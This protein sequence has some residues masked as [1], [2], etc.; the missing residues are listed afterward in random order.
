MNVT[1]DLEMNE[2][3]LNKAIERARETLPFWRSL[4]VANKM[5][6]LKTLKDIIYQR[7]D[8]IA[9]VLVADSARVRFSAE[10]LVFEV[11]NNFFIYKEA[12]RLL[13]KST[14]VTLNPIVYSSKNA[15]VELVPY[16]VVGIISPANSPFF[17]SFQQIIQAVLMGNTVVVKPSEATPQV[18][19]LIQQL[20]SE[21]KVPVGVINIIHGGADLGEKIVHSPHID[22]VILYGKKD[23]GQRALEYSSQTLKPM[24]LGLGGNEAAIVLDD[25]FFERTVNGL[26][27]GAFCNA[28]Q[29][30]SCIRR[31]IAVGDIG[32]QLKEKLTERIHALNLKELEAHE[33]EIGIVKKEHDRSELLAAVREAVEQ[34]ATVITGGVDSR[35][36]SRIRPFFLTDVRPE[37]KIMQEEFMGP[38][39]CLYAVRTVEEAI[40]VANDSC[41]G[42]TGS[43]WTSDFHEGRRIARELH[44]GTVWINESQFYHYRLPY[45][46]IKQSGF[47]K[48]SGTA[49]LREFVYPK[50]VSVEK[51][52]KNNFCWFP[53]EV[54]KINTL[55]TMLVLKHDPDIRARIRA[56]ITMVFGKNKKTG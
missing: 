2:Q 47:G 28:G 55:R 14:R 48:T 7:K 49:G 54:K 13:K 4:S 36:A 38:Y 16:G 17:E 29:T 37:M 5:R 10:G 6:R 50:L 15:Q 40:S 9:G 32:L 12:R 53:Y 21:S 52:R 31:I 41:F 42:L 46:G 56:F 34:G 25:C 23:T 43:V 30:C 18:S 51:N 20:I 11:L 24:V 1:N 27:Y 26:V 19:R 35:E 22:K 39:L 8:E 44:V 3:A 45:G 33:N